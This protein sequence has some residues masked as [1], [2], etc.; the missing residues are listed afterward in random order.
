MSQQLINDVSLARRGRWHTAVFC[1]VAVWLAVGMGLVLARQLG[2]PVVWWELIHPFSVGV[3]TTAIVVYSTHFS[4][5]LT[6][7]ATQDYRAVAGR[8]GLIQVGLVLLL[9]DRAG[10]DWGVLSDA[11][12]VLILSA[13][14]RHAVAIGRALRGSLSGQFAV[15]VPYYLVATGFLAAAVLCAAAAARGAG[16]YSNM[17]AAHQRG[18]VWGFALLTIV[19]TVVTLLPTLSGTPIAPAARAR[20][21]RALVV[22]TAGLAV[23]MVG[24]CAG[25]YLVGGLGQLATVVASALVLHPVVDSVLGNRPQLTA[26]TLSVL[27]GLGWM[28]ALN[29]ADALSILTGAYPRAVT[30]VLLPAFVGAGLL[31]MVTGVLSH[32]LPTLRGGGREKVLAARA[33]ASRSGVARVVL[34]N[35]GAVITVV[36]GSAPEATMSGIIMMG[37]G[38]AWTVAATAWAVFHPRTT[39]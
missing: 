11:A 33:R 21:S 38:L 10:F 29:A 15:T 37:A 17:I 20:C 5:A 6:R 16:N 32:L 26:A 28:V 4:E 12:V 25:W 31:Q 22:H 18:A 2:A 23:A 3:L 19:G 8:V 34:I 27:A 13:L 1:L 30:L 14:A 24:Y 9:A 35:L 39:N 36:P 7:T